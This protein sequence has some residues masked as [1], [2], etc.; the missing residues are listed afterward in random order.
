MKPTVIKKEP[1]VE[2]EP[3]DEDEKKEELES[4]DSSDSEKPQ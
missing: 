1:K 3:A 4:I 2:V